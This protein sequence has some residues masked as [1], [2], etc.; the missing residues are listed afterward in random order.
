MAELLVL[1]GEGEAGSPAAPPRHC[2]RQEAVVRSEVSWAEGRWGQGGMLRHQVEME[3][4]GPWGA[5]RGGG[6]MGV[7]QEAGDCPLPNLRWQ[8]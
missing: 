2:Q 7:A 1:T 5:A 4:S 8:Q 3:L 6:V